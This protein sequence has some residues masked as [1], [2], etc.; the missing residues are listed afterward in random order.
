MSQGPEP[1]APGR[2]QLFQGEG[3]VRRAGGGKRDAVKAQERGLEARKAPLS[4]FSVGV[5]PAADPAALKD[6][7]KVGGDCV[8]DAC[9]G[10]ADDGAGQDRIV[11]G[12]PP[13]GEKGLF[14]F[15][16]SGRF[17]ARGCP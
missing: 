1:F 9:V 8:P 16:G 7:G 11:Q 14:L 12:D 5:N 4:Q 2:A 17:L 6:G 3:G 10:G 15:D 13:P